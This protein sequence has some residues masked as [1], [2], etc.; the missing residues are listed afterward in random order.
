MIADLKDAAALEDSDRFRR[1]AHS[2]KS[3]AEVF[4]ARHL[5]ALAREMEV[6]ELPTSKS[7]T[8]TQLA[9]L[10]EAYAKAATTLSEIVDG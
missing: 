8:P 4:G 2:I 10:D 9:T 3:N 1:A 6:S 7:A 5:S